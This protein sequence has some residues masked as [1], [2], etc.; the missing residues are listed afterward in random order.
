[1][2]T[3]LCTALQLF[4]NYGQVHSRMH[5]TVQVE[6]TGGIE[7]PEPMSIVALDLLVYIRGARLGG[8]F[9]IAI[10][11]GAVLN[12]MDHGGIIHQSQAAALADSHTALFKICGV[13]V[14]GGTAR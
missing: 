1:M 4:D 8:R 12:D 7:R 2:L 5:L 10:F 13:H 3:D 6:G 11:P 14:D 9:G